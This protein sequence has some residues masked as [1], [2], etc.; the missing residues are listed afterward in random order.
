MTRAELHDTFGGNR[1]SGISI[2]NS[3]EMIHLFSDPTVSGRFGASLTD[4]WGEGGVFHYT[5]AGLR[6]NQ[7]MTQAN[8][9]LLTHK[10]VG[11]SL[12]VWRRDHDRV[13]RCLGQ[14]E[15][16]AEAPYYSADAL[17]VDGEMRTVIVFRLRPVGTVAP[18]A[19]MLPS[20]PADEAQVIETER[21][22]DPMT[23]LRR[24]A[25]RVPAKQSERV[26]LARYADHLSGLGHKVGRLQIQPEGERVPFQVDLY[27]ETDNVIFECK[28]SPTREAVRLAVG[29]LIDYRRFVTPTPRLAVLTPTKPRKDL[30]DLCGS[31]MIEAIWPNDDDTFTSSFD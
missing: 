26:L 31:L 11:R 21:L 7:T 17:D 3:A 19:P 14:F 23:Q 9:A 6:G 5:G 20:A 8:R 24:R 29:E 10:D 25:N 22:A 28:A 2:S 30:I 4:G 15:V 1:Q 12:Y 27:D 13:Y 18:G 16:D